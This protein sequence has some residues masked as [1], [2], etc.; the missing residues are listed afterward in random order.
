MPFTEKSLSFLDENHRRN[1][2]DWFNQHRTEYDDHVR[3]PMLDLAERLAPTVL[4]IDPLLI[5]EP[6]RAVCRIHR[7]TRFSRDK[8]MYKRA[9]WL[10]FQRSKGMTHP[11][12]FFE[13]TPDFHHYGCGYYTTPPKVMDQ[14][15]QFVLADDKRFKAAHKAVASLPGCEL[16]GDFYKRPRYPDHPEEKRAWLERRG[17]TAIIYSEYS[18]ALFARDLHKKVAKAFIALAPFYELLMQAHANALPQTA[19]S[20]NSGPARRGGGPAVSRY[21]DDDE[22][23]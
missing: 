14:I 23:W 8:S 17:V 13:F 19:T 16:V 7:D 9:S 1:D 5:P 21:P 15:R 4:R 2:R 6:K 18:A 10:V 11:V 12:W 20:A 22:E 3:R